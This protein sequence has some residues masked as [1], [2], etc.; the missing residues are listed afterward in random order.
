MAELVFALARRL[1][2]YIGAAALL[3]GLGMGAT[4]FLRHVEHQGELRQAALDQKILDK[5]KADIA[6]QTAAA[7]AADQKHAAE[8]KAARDQATTE[9]NNALLPHLDTYRSALARYVSLHRAP[10]GSGQGGGA[11]QSVSGP[12]GGPDLADST[13]ANTIVSEAD[14]E[15]CADAVARLQNVQTWWA[16]VEEAPQ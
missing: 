15:T 7:L 14:V 2:P 6:T 4:L 10:S 5:L 8:V 1:W 3:A 16:S 12:A 11:V 9:A 13:S